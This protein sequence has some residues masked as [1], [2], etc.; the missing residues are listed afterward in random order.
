MNRMRQGQ[1]VLRRHTH[2]AG[3]PVSAG[4]IALSASCVALLVASGF[5]GGRLA[6][7]Y[8][9]RVESEHLRQRR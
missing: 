2:L 3:A 7:R 6:Y 4:L 9:V 5:L 8:G 1:V